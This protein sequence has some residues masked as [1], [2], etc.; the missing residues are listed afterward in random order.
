MMHSLREVQ[1][2][3]TV[4]QH[5]FIFSKNKDTCSAKNDYLSSDLITRNKIRYIYKSILV[6]PFV[7][8]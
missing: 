7:F 3:V 6:L 8:L 2:N 1:I 5:N 4:S